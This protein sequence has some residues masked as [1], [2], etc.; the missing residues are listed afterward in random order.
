[1]WLRYSD[2]TGHRTDDLALYYY[3]WFVG[4][5]KYLILIPFLKLCLVYTYL[6]KNFSLYMLIN[7][8]LKKQSLSLATFIAGALPKSTPSLFSFIKCRTFYQMPPFY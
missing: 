1:M 5:R 4:Q 7:I 8:M 6:L 3:N 2:L